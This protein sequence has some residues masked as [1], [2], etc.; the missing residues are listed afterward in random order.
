MIDIARISWSFM[1]RKKHTSL[2][3]TRKLGSKTISKGEILLAGTLALAIYSALLVRMPHRTP[4]T[5]SLYAG[6]ALSSFY[7][8][9]RW[10]LNI[11]VSL[12]L[13]FCLIVP[14]VLDIIGN[15][16]NLFSRTF[17]FI[18]YDVFTHFTSA[19]LSFI[20]VMWLLLTLTER[21]RYR[22]PSGLIAFFSVT[23]TFSLSAYYEILELCDEKFFGGHRLWTPQDTAHDL[24]SDL[25]GIVF[26]A[27]LYTLATKR[28]WRNSASMN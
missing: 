25:G 23:T 28:Q 1:F 10:R 15:Q 12:G 19:G 2:P 27:I 5:N 4:L 14:V 13:L 9:L 22:L 6:I 18:P 16:F 11:R 26:A 3:A 17:G 20:P 21:F 24:A 8:Y 7:F